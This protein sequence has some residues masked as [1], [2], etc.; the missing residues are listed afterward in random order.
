MMT[1]QS[2]DWREHVKGRAIFWDVCQKSRNV[3]FKI[4]QIRDLSSTEG[5]PNK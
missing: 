4:I 1:D 3:I 5:R 2:F